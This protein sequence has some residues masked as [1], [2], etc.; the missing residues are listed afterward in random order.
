MYQNS[1]L[2]LYL[3]SIDVEKAK[4]VKKL[5]PSYRLGLMSQNRLL[6]RLQLH[7]GYAETIERYMQNPNILSNEDMSWILSLYD[8]SNIPD[9]Q[10]VR[11]TQHLVQQVPE[12]MIQVSITKVVYNIVLMPEPTI[13]VEAIS[14]TYNLVLVPEP[15]IQIIGV[16][17]TQRSLILVPE[18]TIILEGA[19]I[20]T[21]A[22]LITIVPEPTIRVE[23]Q[24]VADANV[25]F[26]V[27]AQVLRPH[28]AD[29]A[30]LQPLTINPIPSSFAVTF[31]NTIGF[32]ILAVINTAP[33]RVQWVVDALNLGA[34]GGA[35]DPTFGNLW[36]NPITQT[37]N[38]RLYNVYITNYSTL[39]NLP[40][41]FSDGIMVA[42]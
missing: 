32:H 4:V 28:S 35:V 33:V 8:I 1:I 9:T 10:A 36:P 20:I 27:A 2:Q 24:V 14:V 38:G 29:F 6:K 11:F 21:P 18:P 12:P 15:T 41:S 39:F 42:I 37:H 19:L 22:T 16:I 3:N 23:A 34:I 7:N 5:L 26:G 30:T 40:V 31:P 17:Q 25:F 13:Q